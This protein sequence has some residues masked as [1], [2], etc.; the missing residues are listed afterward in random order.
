MPSETFWADF[1]RSLTR[2]GLRGV[3]VVISDAHEGL[4]AAARKLLGAGWQRCRIHFQ[5]NLLARV[6]K[7]D[8]PVVSAVVKTVF[9]EK[10]RRAQFVPGASRFRTDR[11]AEGRRLGN[12][13]SAAR[14]RSRRPR[15]LKRPT[16]TSPGGCRPAISTR[17]EISPRH[18]LR[19]TLYTRCLRSGLRQRGW[20]GQA[21]SDKRDRHP[22]SGGVAGLV[23]SRTVPAC[24]AAFG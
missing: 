17:C 3:Q 13:R 18:P 20:P 24:D 21:L 11:H 2:R 4:K 7:T 1:L 19:E 15:R 10:D 16:I 6:G 23:L 5:R 22:S 14:P 12:S 9:A 8:K